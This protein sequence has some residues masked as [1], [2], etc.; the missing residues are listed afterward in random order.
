MNPRSA[1]HEVWDPTFFLRSAL[2]WPVGR[3][4][5]L[6]G[7]HAFWPQPDDLTR[8][9]EGEPPVRFEAAKPR[10]RRV[11]VPADDR[12]DAR[13]AV[14]R[15]V[16]TRARSW[17]DVTNALVWAAFPNAK[18]ALHTRQHGIIAGR[19]GLDLRLPGARTPEQDALAM[20]DEGGVA[21]VCS[22][23][24]R[25]D[26]ERALERDSTKDLLQLVRDRSAVPMVFG[27][28]IYES[29]VRG[30]A[31]SVRSIARVIDIDSVPAAAGC[32]QAADHALAA[33][34][35]GAATVGRA[36]FAS[37]AVE[38]SLAECEQSGSSLFRQERHRDRDPRGAL[39]NG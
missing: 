18:L 30:P 39:T 27:H 15:R 28:A 25:G 4:A 16:P 20:L 14:A 8:L 34:L 1:A 37:I 12:Y 22:R 36:A 26:L 21:I 3:A 38:E 2:F 5:R 35:S 11:R 31:P 33:F 32:V 29:L 19:L 24:R 9:F 10:R 7:A 23:S 17:H 6:L 13:I